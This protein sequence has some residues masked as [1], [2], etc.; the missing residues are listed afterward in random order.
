VDN[1][2]N[3]LQVEAKPIKET[4]Q[5]NLIVQIITK[6]D[7]ITINDN[8]EKRQ[9]ATCRHGKGKKN[10]SDCCCCELPLLLHLAARMETGLSEIYIMHS[11]D[12]EWNFETTIT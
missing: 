8:G 10:C 4:Q 5:I 6:H 11:N 3:T 2:N 7:I 1:N 12:G 9:E